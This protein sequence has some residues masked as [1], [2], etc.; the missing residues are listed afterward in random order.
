MSSRIRV[1]EAGED[2]FA[3]RKYVKG[4]SLYHLYA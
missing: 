3:E 1:V 2:N 4:E